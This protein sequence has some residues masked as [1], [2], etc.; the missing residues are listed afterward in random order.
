[1]KKA[2]AVLVFISALMLSGCGVS[3][4]HAYGV[5]GKMYSAPDICQAVAACKAAKETECLY[6]Q[7]TQFSCEAQ[8]KK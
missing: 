3:M 5:S 7:S 6:P 8:E 4:S 1:M 2:I